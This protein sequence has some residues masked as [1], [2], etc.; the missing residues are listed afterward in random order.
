MKKSTWM[1]LAFVVIAMFIFAGANA[2][3]L[4]NYSQ[5]NTTTTYQTAGKSFRLYVMPDPIYSPAPGY[6]AATNVGYNVDSRWTWVYAGLTGAPLTGA[7]SANNWVTFTNP[8]AGNYSVTVA[9]SNNVTGCV[10]GTPITQV[11]EVINAPLA[12]IGGSTAN[13]NYT[14]TGASPYTDCLPGTTGT[15][16][17]TVTIT[18]DADLPVAFRSYALAITQSVGNVLPDL[19]TA[20]GAPV[21][22]TWDYPTSNKLKTGRV[23]AIPGGHTWTPNDVGVATSTYTF[24]TPTLAV[25]GGKPTRYTFSIAQASDAGATVG[26]VSAVSQ[27]SD[28]D[29]LTNAAGTIVPNAYVGVT[30]ISYIVLPAPVTGPIYHISNTYAY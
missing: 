8:A 12:I 20:D 19:A 17:I 10:D 23:P 7:A 26:I 15:E 22:T 1:K 27:K 13:V 18:E 3:I 16:T 24:P 5:D 29:F 4:V 2:Q 21:V 11:I 28:F 14:W 6:D 30:S 9:E 25:I